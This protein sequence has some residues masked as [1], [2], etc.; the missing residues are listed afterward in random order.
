MMSVLVQF[1]DPLYHCFTFQDFQL[2][3]TLEEFSELLGI[4]VLEQTP[5]TSWEKTLR[6]EEIA[7][8]LHLTKEEVMDNWET[9]SGAKG[10]LAKFLVDRANQFW[11]RLDF[12]AFEDILALLIYGMVLFP[13]SDSFVDVNAV[14][15]FMSSNPVPTLLGYILHALYARTAQKRGTL[16]CCA[17]LLAR[18]FITHLPK[19]CFEEQVRN[20]LGL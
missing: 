19:I 13:N 17:P 10:F 1:Y 11:D 5:F 8:T 15:I 9:R 16:I 2:V 12:Q 7:A 14:K 4:S 20:G 18:W 3:P 6:P